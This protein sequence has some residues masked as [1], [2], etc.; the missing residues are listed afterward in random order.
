[1]YVLLSACAWRQTTHTTYN[2]QHTCK[3]TSYTPH[4]AYACVYY[5]HDTVN[6]G[7]ASNLL[8]W[9]VALLD[10]GVHLRFGILHEDGARGV[11]L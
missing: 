11:A 4:P 7:V 5:D 10:L 2:T 8:G 9:A 6:N 1:M 3:S